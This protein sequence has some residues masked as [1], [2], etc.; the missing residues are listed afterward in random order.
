MAIVPIIKIKNDS[1]KGFKY[2]NKMDFDKKVHILYKKSKKVVPQDKVPQDK[3][4]QDKV[5]QDKVPQDKVPQDKVP[6]IL[7]KEPQ[8]KEKEN[9]N[10]SLLNLEILNSLSEIALINYL[11]THNI[12]TLPTETTK[13]Q[14]MAKIA[15]SEL[16][17]SN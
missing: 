16:I 8:Q 5:P 4:P 1:E 6:Q 7:T 12:E 14:L 11:K 15:L 17:R 10:T 9:K 2:I 3:V 13:S